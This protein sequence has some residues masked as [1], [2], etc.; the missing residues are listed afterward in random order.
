QQKAAYGFETW[1]EFRRVLFRSTWNTVLT[2]FA[3]VLSRRLGFSS[4]PRTETLAPGTF[5]MNSCTWRLKGMS[6]A[7]CTRSRIEYRWLTPMR[8]EALPLSGLRLE[9]GRAHV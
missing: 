9:I 7:L 4:P 3:E 2:S 5:S 1:L 6:L 8:L